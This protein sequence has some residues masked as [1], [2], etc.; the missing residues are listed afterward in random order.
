MHNY[1]WEGGGKDEAG[2]SGRTTAVGWDFYLDNEIK[3]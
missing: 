2:V 1:T 3:F